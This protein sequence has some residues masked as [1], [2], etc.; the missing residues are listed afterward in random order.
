[1][2]LNDEVVVRGSVRKAGQEDTIGGPEEKLPFMFYSDGIRGLT[3]LS[4][5]QRREYDALFSALVMAGRGRNTQ[6]DLMTLL[7]QANLGAILIESV[8]LE[9]TIYL[10]S[11]R[12]QNSGDRRHR[13]QTFAWGAS[14]T[15]IRA[16]LGQI[17]GVQGL[18][19]DTFDDWRLPDVH[20]QSTQA[21]QAL[22]P[23][24]EASR[25]RV[26]K[27]WEAE[28]NE[29][30]T[31]RLPELIRRVL[32]LAPTDDTRLALC[33]SLVTWT[34]GALQRSAWEEAENA[35]RLLREV[36]PEYKYSA[37]ELKELID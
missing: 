22:L 7:W 26:M 11:R 19:R 13:G 24:V 33:H 30:W 37:H 21:Y 27:R 36:D 35:L 12:P 2:K 18:H 9:Q 6:D 10:S 32:A 15:E 31:D 25:E 14:G 28:S 20:A 16:D 1:M 4:T 34:V 17:A 23:H 8:P 5:L 29:A 3:L